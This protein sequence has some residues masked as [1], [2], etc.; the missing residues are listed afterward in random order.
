[1]TGSPLIR[2]ALLALALAALALPA[3]RLTAGRRPAETARPAPE[4]PAAAQTAIA[5]TFT[6]PVPPEEITITALGKPAATLH[7]PGSASAAEI[8][9]VI[10]P[11][12]IDL[13]IG[14]KWSGGRSPNALRVEAAVDGAP[15]EDATFWGDSEIEDVLTIPGRSQP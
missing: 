15:C 4:Q 9:A 6:S 1:M 5:L 13:V 3:W 2:L 8:S 14:A 11:E 7:P 12:G 10:P